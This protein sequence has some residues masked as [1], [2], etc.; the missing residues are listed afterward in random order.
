[1]SYIARA[2]YSYDYRY[3]ITVTGRWDGSSKFAKGHRWGFFPSFSLAW[4]ITNEKFFPKFEW[5]NQIKLRGGYGVVGN[6][7]IADYMYATLYSP[8][9]NN[10]VPSYATDGRRGTPDITWEKQKQTNIGI[11]LSFLNHRLGLTLD[12]FFIN[13]S[14]LLMTHNLAN[15]TGYIYTTENIGELSNKGF[16]MTITATPISNRDFNSNVSANLGLDR[17]KVKKLYGG[18][19]R[20]LSG[21]RTGNIF[22]GHSLSNIYTLMSGGI[23][24]EW[25]RSQWEGLDYSGHTV[26]LGDLFVRDL[27]DVN[28]E[29]PDG[30]IDSN[31]RYIYGNMDPKFYGGFSTDLTWKGISLNAIFSYSVGGHRISSYYEGLISSIGESNASVDLLNSWTPENTGAE[32]P[33][34]MRNASG[35]SA[36]GAGDTDRYI[37]DSSF[38]RLSNLSL[39]YNF[40]QRWLTKARINNLRVYFTAGNVFT[41]TKYKGYDPEYG[42]GNGY[43]PTERTYA[44]GLAF[45]MF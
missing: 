37:Q 5:L 28:G 12:A 20:I 25:N 33:R 13:N 44:I 41:I 17:N 6:Q 22:I 35:Y 30:V 21:S 4:D 24:N 16:E 38:L 31:D 15:S 11:D 19:E 3:F 40:P 23:A 32:F 43:F 1:M 10:G 27:N 42:D 14:N 18:V 9:Y 29:G 36:Y 2:N 39:S 34:R 8:K 45:S 7:D 26:G